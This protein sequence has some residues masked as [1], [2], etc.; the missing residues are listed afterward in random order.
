MYADPKTLRH[1]RERP[2]EGKIT[3]CHRA[4]EGGGKNFI[5]VVTKNMSLRMILDALRGIG[6]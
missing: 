1:F 6:V 3:G 4:A 2:L 5:F